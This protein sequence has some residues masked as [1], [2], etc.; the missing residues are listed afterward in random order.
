MSDFKVGDKV[1]LT[2]RYWDNA[3]VSFGV[4][5]GTTHVVVLDPYGVE[6]IKDLDGDFWY[7]AEGGYEVELV[8]PATEEGDEPEVTGEVPDLPAGAFSAP[9]STT[10]GLEEE[11]T[12]L[13]GLVADLNGEIENLKSAQSYADTTDERLRADVNFLAGR[14]TQIETQQADLAA[15]ATVLSRSVDDRFAGLNHPF[16]ALILAV[17]VEKFSEAEL[18]LGRRRY[19]PQPVR[20]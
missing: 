7:V 12:R 9:K 19:R 2:G 8:E 10:Q 11:V 20:R 16:K 5:G 3:P 1:K 4:T 6:S 17:G 13:Q 18:T 14:T 15:D